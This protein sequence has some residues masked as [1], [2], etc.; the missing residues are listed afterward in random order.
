M[1]TQRPL[2]ASFMVRVHARQ[3]LKA[4]ISFVKSRSA[5]TS[6]IKSWHRYFPQG[7]LTF[8]PAV[9]QAR[10][11]DAWM[12]SRRPDAV[13]MP[14]NTHEVQQLMRLCSRDQ[15]LITARGAGRGYVGGCVPQQGGIVVDFSSMNRIL[16]ISTEDGVAVVQPGV[17]TAELQEAVKK[18]GWFYPPDPASFKECTLG[19]NVATNAGGP[20]CLKYGVTRHYVLGLEVVLADGSLARVGGRTHKNKTGLDLVGLFV[21][22]EGLLGLVTEITLRIIPHP[23]SR[24]VL[25][26][27]FLDATQAATAVNMLFAQ[28]LLPSA[29][30]VADK[31]TVTTARAYLGDHP[32][33]SGDAFMLVEFDGHPLAVEEALG[34]AK[35]VLKQCGAKKMTAAQDETRCE[36]LW[37][38]RRQCSE[39]LKQSGRIKFNEDVVVPRS[40]L[41]DLFEFSEALE[42]K[43][44]YGVASFGHAGDGNIHVNL[45]LSEEQLRDRPRLKRALDELFDK[46]IE[47]GGAI[48]G[49]HG[50][51]LAKIP[52]WSKATSSTVRMIHSQIKQAL[53]P[54]HLLNPGKFI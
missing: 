32:L 37:E 18:E 11:G 23:P 14:R 43:Y 41:V 10:S 12:A 35:H 26:A 7:Q 51:G 45:M 25:G 8:D 4:S 31:L 24:V 15:V 13:F 2:E 42:K 49:E 1:V 46:V 34:L 28:G 44:G 36:A 40:R 22:S 39:A 6:R 17:I 19:G 48:T 29:L 5:I 20:R 30:E 9:L 50:I 16:E 47:W 33:F 3:L 27:M 21:G 38:L 52:W 53:D 54:K